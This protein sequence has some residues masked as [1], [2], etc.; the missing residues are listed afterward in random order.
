MAAATQSIYQVP[1]EA[2][3]RT[4]ERPASE[5]VAPLMCAG[6]TTFVAL[7]KS[8]ARHVLAIQGIGGVGHLGVQFAKRFG[9]E[10]IAIDRGKDKKDLAV[11]MSA[12]LH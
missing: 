11:K 2:L 10:T 9:F 3:T 1:V 12:D 7:H 6:V 8:G 4:P 5:N